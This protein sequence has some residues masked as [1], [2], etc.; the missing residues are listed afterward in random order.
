MGRSRSRSRDR[1]RRGRDRTRSRER[2]KKSSKRRR[3]VS[4]GSD[5]SREDRRHKV[6]KMVSRYT[7][8]LILGRGEGEARWMALLHKL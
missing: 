3:S 1:E 5:G 8:H 4:S 6:E 7:S 2:E